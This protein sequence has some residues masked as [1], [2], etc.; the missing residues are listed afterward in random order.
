[1]KIFLAIFLLCSPVLACN[2]AIIKVGKNCPLNY[3][4]SGGYCIKSR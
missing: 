4:S 3:Y 2:D 1:M